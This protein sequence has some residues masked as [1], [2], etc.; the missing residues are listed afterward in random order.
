MKDTIY[1]A[2][3]NPSAKIPSKRE[4]D[5]CY[6]IYA[7]FEKN[8]I[9][10]EK[11]EI[12]LIPT[13]I[14][15]AFDKKY[16]LNCKR[17]RGSTGKYGMTIVSGQIDSGYRGE[18]FIAIN[19]TSNRTIIISKSFPDVSTTNHIVWFPY[20]KAIGQIALEEVPDVEVKEISYD[21][22]KAI[23]SERK[24]GMLGSS[25]K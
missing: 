21:E 5:G 9:E 2:K 19:N 20:N 13:G 15:S 8:E 24:T 16:R 4:E 14:A 22:L 11:G 17:E 18:I 3:V 25:G 12:K 23:D 10:I 7:C 6:D 1:F